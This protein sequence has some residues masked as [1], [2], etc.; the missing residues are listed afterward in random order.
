MNI[1]ITGANSGIALAITSECIRLGHHVAAI[2]LYD[3]NLRAL[4]HQFPEQ[5]MV[6]S[7]CDVTSNR[8][9]AEAAAEMQRRW[10]RIDVLVNC[11]C[12]AVF[13]SFENT[14][15]EDIRRQFEVNYYGYLNCIRAVLPIMK[16][17]HSGVIHNFSSG[18]G[19]SGFG[20]LIGYTS[21]KGAIEGMTRTLSIEFEP[22]GITVN[23]VHPPLTNTKSASALGIP[24][25]AM[26]DPVKVGRNLARKVGQKRA[27]I[28][29]DLQTFLY[30]W[31]VRLQPLA[32]G[33]L[34]TRLSEKANLAKPN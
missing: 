25:E 26:A 24:S 33:R 1:L 31:A 34:F 29:A 8:D 6:F 30:L 19:I 4:E 32:V 9:V 21:T 12:L 23:L 13:G 7:P 14:T 2:D 22:F 20:N 28:T 18:V 16:D 5:M 27:V 15:V 10:S 3:E 17:Q 11:A